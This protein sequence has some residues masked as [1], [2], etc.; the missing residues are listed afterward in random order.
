MLGK[1]F[2]YKGIDFTD[3]VQLGNFDTLGYSII[4]TDN[5]K[6]TEIRQNITNKSNFH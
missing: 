5:N 2:K 3:S 4:I 1:N 6:P